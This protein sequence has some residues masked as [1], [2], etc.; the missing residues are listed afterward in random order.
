[1]SNADTTVHYTPVAKILH[2]LVAGMIVLQFVLAKLA[3]LAP[4]NLREL[5]LLAN[6][7]SVGITILAVAVVRII[8]RFRNKPPALPTSMPKWQV[9]ASH[10]S[11]WSLYALLFAI[12]ITGWLM[13]S[14]SAYSVSWFNLFQLPDFVSPNPELKE[15][16]EET[17]ETLAKLLAVLASV[18]IIAAFKH[19]V[20]NKDDIL[21]RMVSSVS[22]ALFVIVAAFG[23]AWLGNVGKSSSSATDTSP[24]VTTDGGAGV[25]A[26]VMSSDLPAWQVDYGTSYVRFIG[27]QAGAEFEGV[28]ESWSADMRFDT[29]ELESSVFDVAVDTASGNTQDTDRDDTLTD[30]E[31]FDSI[32]FPEAYFRASDFSTSEDGYVA[33]GQLIIKGLASPAQLLFTVAADGDKR[34]L[35]G[36]AQLD[37]LALGVGTGEWEDTEWVG[38]DVRVEVRVEATLPR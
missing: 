37:R 13:S 14:A 34:V 15:I 29:D 7:K 2:W 17:H 25:D 28:W 33:S 21:S 23:A 30:P 9:T 31:W 20:V 5:A 27:D 12:P 24:A 38:K 16:F 1:M 11:H 36:T 19:A 4:S 8:W 10:V 3:D 6:H 18:H 35:T 26:P 32:N 22:V